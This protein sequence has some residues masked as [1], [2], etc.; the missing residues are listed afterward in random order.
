MES[1]TEENRLYMKIDIIIIKK[2]KKNHIIWVI[3]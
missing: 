3:F 2:K 1:A